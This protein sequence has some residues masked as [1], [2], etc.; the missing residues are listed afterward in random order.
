DGDNWRNDSGE[1]LNAIIAADRSL[2]EQYCVNGVS[3]ENTDH[4]W[5]DTDYDVFDPAGVISGATASKETKIR[6]ALKMSLLL[7]GAML[8]L[9]VGIVLVFRRRISRSK[10]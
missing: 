1:V 8:V 7:A 10:N 5:N 4:I 9:C 3:S 6:D 2:N